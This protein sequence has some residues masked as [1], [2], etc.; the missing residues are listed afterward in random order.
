MGA[1]Y[2]R[3]IKRQKCCE[4]SVETLIERVKKMRALNCNPSDIGMNSYVV[5]R[6]L[7]NKSDLSSKFF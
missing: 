2:M 3:F 7:S 4:D 6:L 1:R 5:K